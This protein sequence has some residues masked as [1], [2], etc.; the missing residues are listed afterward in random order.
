[1]SPESHN[2]AGPRRG[3][4]S[5]PATEA[6]DLELLRGCALF[7][8][9][10]DADLALVAGKVARVAFQ[11]N[12]PIF[13]KQDPGDSLYIIRHGRVKISLLN[14]DGKDLIINIYGP[15]EVFG[16]M[17][18]FDGLPRS[19]TA[20]AINKVE[21]LRL[22]RPAFTD[23]LA[24]LPQLALNIIAL[25]S[26]RLR[27]TTEQTELLGLF[28]AYERVSFKLLQLA[29]TQGGSGPLTLNLSQQELAAMLGL[30]REWLNKVLNIFA[31]QGVVELQWGKIVVKNPEELKR[32]I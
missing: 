8:S 10:R 20:T 15:G 25:L 21:A 17:S 13:M 31:E 30:T 27:Y 28:G 2:P 1:M 6:S 12:E 16:E 22:G 29:Q 14:S 5:V 19:A 4:A 23:L 32:W 24:A 3:K 9:L 11:R 26:R 7:E 18:L